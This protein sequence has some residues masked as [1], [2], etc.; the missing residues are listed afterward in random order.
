MAKSWFLAVLPA[1][2]LLSPLAEAARCSS[3]VHESGYKKSA[4]TIDA[5]EFL[6]ADGPLIPGGKVTCHVSYDLMSGN[7]NVMHRIETGV[8]DGI[9]YR[10]YYSDGSGLVQGL[11]ENVLDV[12]K[13]K[14][15]EN[16]SLRCRKDEMNDTHYCSMTREALTIGAF[17]ATSRF[18]S[19]GSEYF[20]GSSIAIRVDKQEP[21]TAP[22]NPGFTNSQETA[23]IAAM[24]TGTSAL[25]RYVQWP[26][27]ANKDK[28]I[29]L[30]G[31]KSALAIIDTLNKQLQ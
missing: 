16:W 31:F 6:V 13:D 3:T 23:L 17:G 4:P 21:I 30:F 18:V 22:A 7:H 10:F 12:L 27:E 2:L 29:S 5:P 24:S 14:Y 25:T 28:K 19:V 26:Y 1:A 9:K 15:S 11:A 8:L 20:P